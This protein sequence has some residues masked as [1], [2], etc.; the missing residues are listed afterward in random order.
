MAV[1]DDDGRR[2]G[3]TSAGCLLYRR[4]PAG[5]HVLLAHMGGPFWA[6]KDDGAWSIP[7]G[8]YDETVEDPLTVAQREFEE[9]LGSPVPGDLFL[10]LGETRQAGGKRVRIW[11]AEGDFDP[12]TQHSN[13]CTIEWPRGSGRFRE[14][15]EVDRVEWFDLARAHTKI[16]HSQ[17]TFL[18]RLEQRLLQPAGHAG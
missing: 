5:V 7:K 10:D 13:T 14:I 8:E 18:E 1:R 15:P 2:M 17:K 11:A 3:R 4:T 9:E 12:A 16:L 6:R